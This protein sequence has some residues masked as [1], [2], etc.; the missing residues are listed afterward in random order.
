LHYISKSWHQLSFLTAYV[1]TG[2]SPHDLLKSFLVLVSKIYELILHT[3]L[4]SFCL[5][6]FV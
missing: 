2:A 5:N 1:T 6:T 3:W 4:Q